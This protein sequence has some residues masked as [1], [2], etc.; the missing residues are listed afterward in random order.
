MNSLN[1]QSTLED[2]ITVSYFFPVPFFKF[3]VDLNTLSNLE[4]ALTQLQKK[5]PEW[6]SRTSWFTPDSLHTKEPF[7][8]W[9]EMHVHKKISNILDEMRIVRKDH[10]LTSSWANITWGDFSHPTHLH[11][12]AFLSGIAYIRLPPGAGKTT[13]DDPKDIARIVE[14]D[15]SE[16]NH[17]NT[18]MITA[19]PVVG[20][21]FVFPSYLKHSVKPGNTNAD[22]RISIAFNY[23]LRGEANRETQPYK[24]T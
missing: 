1:L 20:D 8:S 2:N 9:F 22:P 13:F 10:Y 19:N 21:V 5:H 24:W 14:P 7:K 11:P 18:R 3:T 23:H 6:N 15:L 12:N 16:Q 17:L 4:N